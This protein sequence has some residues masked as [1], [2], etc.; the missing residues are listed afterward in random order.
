MEPWLNALLF[1]L[2]PGNCILCEAPTFRHL[3]LCASCERDLPRV[4]HPCRRCGLPFAAAGDVCGPCLVAPPPFERCFAPFAYSWPVDR[5]I[6]D[7]KNH[8]RLILGKML[9]HALSNAWLADA[10]PMNLPD[11]LIPVPLHK[12]RLRTRGFNQSLEIA[13]V[14]ADAGGIRLDNRLCRRIREAAPQKS[15]T[16]RQRRHNL[17][18]AFVLDRSPRGERVGI[19]DDVVTTAA[20]VSEIGR[21]LLSSGAVSVEVIALARTLRPAGADMPPLRGLW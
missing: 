13:E 8:N 4:P 2:I 16:A 12:H 15:L 10:R 18:G 20:T 17:R 7:F 19:V 11:T 5:L 14:L 9:A 1:T 6:N 3:D 21:L